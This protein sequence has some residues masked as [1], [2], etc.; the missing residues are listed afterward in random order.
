MTKP[1]EKQVFQDKH[2]KPAI[3][4]SLAIGI[5]GSLWFLLHWLRDPEVSLFS[6]VAMNAALL[7]IP[8][9]ALALLIVHYLTR[10][11]WTTSIKRIPESL[12]M[13]VIV[14]VIVM[15]FL[16]FSGDSIFPWKSSAIQ[17]TGLELSQDHEHKEVDHDGH[18]QADEHKHSHED[19]EGTYSGEEHKDHHHDYGVHLDDASVTLVKG[20]KPYLNSLFLF[21]RVALFA[22]LWIGMAWRF[23]KISQKQDEDRLHS[24]SFKLQKISTYSAIF[25]VLTMSFFAVDFLMSLY[26]AWYSTIIGFYYLSTAFVAALAVFVLM[27]LLLKKFGYLTE[28]SG[29]NHLHDL[30]KLLYGM[31]GFWAYIAFSQYFLIWYANIPEGVSFFHY[32]LENSWEWLSWALMIIHGV[33]PL[34]FFISTGAKR[35]AK[36][37]VLFALFILLGHVVEFIWIVLPNYFNTGLE[38][39]ISLLSSLLAVSGFYFALF[40]YFLGKSSLVPIGDPRLPE[41]IAHGRDH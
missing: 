25:L 33:I 16:Q 6:M 24:H 37:M 7:A 15:F 9:G 32:R 39:P 28:V 18:H 17:K 23:S 31:N 26:P 35:K 5:L 10:A 38:L 14:P 40:F 29:A 3:F 36:P 2:K 13:A 19:S 4:L 22:L 20:K 30:G 41:S 8:T 1:I 12:A 11:G 27:Y 21:I 34:V